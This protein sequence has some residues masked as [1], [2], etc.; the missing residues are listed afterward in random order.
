MSAGNSITHDSAREHVSGRAR[1]VDDMPVAVGQLHVALGLTTIAHG[2]L[3][4]LD[5]TAVR[6]APGIVD[7]ITFDDLPAA[8]DIGAVFPGD[9]LLIDTAIEYMGQPMFAVA[10]RSHREARAAV[11][12]VNVEYDAAPPRL[13]I[14]ASIDDKFHVR[15]PHRMQRGDADAALQ[16]APHRLQGEILIGGQEHF[17][18]EGQVARAEPEE[19]GGVTVHSSNQNPTETQ[20][21]IAA[22]LGIAMHR[23]NVVV[24]RMG[25]GFG[26]KETHATTC[27]VLAALFAVRLQVTVNCRLSR[28]D[29]MLVT[30]KRHGFLNRYDVG[31]DDDGRILA[32]R[33]CLAGQCGSSPDLSDAIVDRAMFH[34]DNAYYLPAVTIDGLRCKTHTVSN[35]AFRGFGGPQGMMAME[36]VIDEIAFA[37]GK[38]PLLIRQ[39]NLY[40]DAPRNVTPYHQEVRQFSVPEM[41]DS[42]LENADY[43]QRRQAIAAYNAASPVLKKGLALTPV[44]FGIS[45]T[46]NHLNQAGAL[47]H[48]Y[49]DGSFQLNHGGTEM[50]QGLMVK[51][52]QIV[53]TELGMSA[54]RLAIMATRT[55]KV[56]NTSPTA[57]SSGT[58][59]N[60]M[61]ALNAARKLRER[62]SDFL[63]KRHSVAEADIYFVD[64]AIHVNGVRSVKYSWP[65]LAKAAY[66]ARTHLSATG[67]YRTPD[68]Y[69]DRSKASGRPFYYFANGASI[70]EVLID[71]LT[72]ETRLLRTDII[73][74]VGRSI[75]PAID[76]G[77]I[78]GAYVQGVGWLTHEELHWDDKG[79]LLT[80]GPAT[81]KIPAISDMP[82][83][84]NVA[85]LGDST[86]S[87]ATVFHSKAVGEPPLMLAISAFAA[88][89]DAIAS[90]AGHRLF[91]QL[92]APATPEEVLRVCTLMRNADQTQAASGL[93][94]EAQKI[95]AQTESVSTAKGQ[96]NNRNT[97]NGQRSDRG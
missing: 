23:V 16:Q 62:L 90:L 18:L 56:P 20:H 49:S 27:A 71:T 88:I 41:M 78:E 22:V 28:R 91:P 50:G 30:G 87:E 86:N 5:L 51:V 47:L 95:Y 29:D 70:T 63:V 84:F 13:N 36:A 44:K 96:S 14:A 17:Y 8:T 66:L 24:R 35:T 3:Q 67:Y 48:L 92:N 73:Q 53:A 42:L 68:I 82:A 54:D 80:D 39:V 83:E 65:E 43:A 9:P 31:F 1:Y 89:R 15:P 2:K 4:S 12:L 76:L 25:G 64:D 6:A 74:D 46:V 79:R 19:H 10:A 52:S 69:Y 37:L 93:A 94:S 72:G 11:L 58:D 26:G 57:A 55:D 21:L 59:L 33:Y 40:G 75:N 7:V 60:G 38:E 34:C 61:A 85:L 45:F 97:G 32:I 77:Q 81:Y